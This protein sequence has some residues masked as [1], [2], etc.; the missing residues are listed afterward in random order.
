MLGESRARRGHGA[1]D[2][3]ALERRAEQVESPRAYL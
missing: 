2:L 1:G 3:A